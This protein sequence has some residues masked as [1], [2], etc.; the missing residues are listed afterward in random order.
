MGTDQ[1]SFRPALMS[2]IVVAALALICELPGS[3]SFFLTPVSFLGYGIAAFVIVGM[4]VYCVIKKR[5][6]RGASVLLVLLLPVVL[7]RPI[8]WT[9]E[10]VHLGLTVG[11]DIGQLGA[12]ST[13]QD[14]NFIAYDWSIGFAGS[15]TFL[16]HDATDEITLPMAQHTHPLNS[17]NGFG[18]E[19]AGNVQRLISHYYVCNF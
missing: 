14:G 17:E 7:W 1:W 16:I 8:I 9:T 18:E 15:N 3:V 6:Q 2:L 10:I 19:C 13:S 5:P 4:T 12:P 11:F